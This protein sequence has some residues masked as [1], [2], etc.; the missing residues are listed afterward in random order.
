MVDSTKLTQKITFQVQ[1]GNTKE[2]EDVCTVY[3]YIAGLKNSE[4][5]INFLGGNAEEVLNVS[6]RY[7]KVLA[8]LIPQTS[9]IVHGGAVYDI[10]SPPDDVLFKHTEL[11]FRV[12]RQIS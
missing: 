8:E 2:W 10:I 4:Y 11:K 6:V 12:R 3:A 7:K 5:W 1:D 9:R